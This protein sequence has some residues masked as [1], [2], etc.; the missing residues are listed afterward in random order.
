VWN[1]DTNDWQIGTNPA[2]TVNEVLSTVSSLLDSVPQ[3]PT[4]LLEH[5]FRVVTMQ[6]GISVSQM[7]LNAT[8]RVNCPQTWP[9]ESS[10]IETRLDSPSNC[11][12]SL[13]F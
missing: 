5:D 7:I 6:V 10:G 2:Y 4:L 13:D 8:G 11:E 12:S 9:A 3:I 1:H